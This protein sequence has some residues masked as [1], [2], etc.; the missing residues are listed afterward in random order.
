[1]EDNEIFQVSI[2]N[3]ENFKAVQTLEVR[4]DSG[5]TQFDRWKLENELEIAKKKF[6]VD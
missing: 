4:L 3:L 6:R 5:N 1:M 2:E